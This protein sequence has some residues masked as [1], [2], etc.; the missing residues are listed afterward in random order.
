[1]DSHG[2]GA[3]SHEALDRESG[4]QIHEPIH[5]AGVLLVGRNNEGE[6]AREA[7]IAYDNGALHEQ[8]LGVCI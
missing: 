5:C 3:A 4:A 7:Q 8:L 1:M 2:Y 6:E